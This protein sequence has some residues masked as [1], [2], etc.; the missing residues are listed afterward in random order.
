MPH[1][2]INVFDGSLTKVVR[3]SGARAPRDGWYGRAQDDDV[4][5]GLACISMELKEL[6]PTH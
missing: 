4:A 5:L 1:M 6:V 3:V 2:S